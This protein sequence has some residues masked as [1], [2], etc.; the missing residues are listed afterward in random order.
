[1]AGRV[2]SI[3]IGYSLTRVCEL[4][5]KAKTP[6][7]YKSFSVPTLQGVVND[8]ALQ[9]DT[10]YLEG[11][12]GAIRENNVKAKQVI[13]SISSARIAAREVTIPLVKQNRIG[14]V[15]RAK[16]VDLFPMDIS[17]HEL[18]YTILETI[19]EGKGGQQYKVMVLAVP[20]GLLKGYY[21]LAAGLRLE[22]AAI[23]YAGNS[24][25]QI[26]KKECASGTHLIAKIDENATLLMVVQDQ[27]IALTRNVGYGVEE[28]LQIVGDSA[29]WGTIRNIRQAIQV[30]EQNQCID[31]T[32][33]EE[34]QGAQLPSRED[35][36]RRHITEALLP[37][38][39]NIAKVIDY[40]A[41]RNAAVIDKVHITGVG[42]NFLGMDELMQREIDYP[43]EVIRK[44]EGLN[45]E[46]YFKDG[47][48]GEYLSC[49]GA[50]IA[51]VNFKLHEDKGKG[52][53]KEKEG[54]AASGSIST[55]LVVL[56]WVIFAAGLL[57]AAGMTALSIVNTM[58]V[59]KKNVD[60]Q[61]QVSELKPIV[62][63]YNS[64][65]DVLTE[66]NKVK[67]MYAVTESRNDELY[68][69]ML[70][71]EQKLPADVNVVAFTADRSQITMSMNVSSKGEAAAAIEQLRTFESL[72]PES[73]TVTAVTEELEEEG[74]IIVNFTVS[75]L[76]APL[77]R[78]EAEE[79]GTEEAAAENTAA[80]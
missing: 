18:A 35:E 45:L 37:V 57:S 36:A 71:L 59:E 52:K 38:V 78:D 8:G 22:V 9:L 56:A 41:S 60:L 55:G 3:E 30:V 11:L 76:Y 53:G 72:L 74:G 46:K 12:R 43:V 27:K 2:L 15:V 79:A 10:H 48:F 51:P 28:A 65:V 17:Q 32:P 14:D 64:Y 73:V 77:V 33:T 26:V 25:F 23:D 34:E 21:D 13:F 68:E 7:V 58:A 5:Y 42:G 50:V 16:A 29:A 4:D 44:V 20:A 39:G 54:S 47:F 63:I 19:G 70:E 49:I 1:M 61:H 6:R 67:A 80:Q 69:F 24:L 31:L 40:Y 75:A 62:D 66:Y